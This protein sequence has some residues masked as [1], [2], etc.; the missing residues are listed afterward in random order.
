MTKHIN[1]NDFLSS[2]FENAH[3]VKM[4]DNRVTIDEEG[5]YKKNYK[6][7]WKDSTGT[8][9]DDTVA[10]ILHCGRSNL[11]VIDLD[12]HKEGQDGVK[13]FEELAE[14]HGETIPDTFSVS[15]SSGGVHYY[16]SDEGKPVGPSAGKIADGVDV[17]GD[18]SIIVAPYTKLV[19]PDGTV[20]EYLPLNDSPVLP[21][22]QWLREEAYNASKEG[23]GARKKSQ[24][25]NVPSSPL[26]FDDDE[27][28]NYAKAALDGNVLEMFKT[29]EGARADT[30]Y[31]GAKGCAKAGVPFEVAKDQL[32]AAARTTLLPEDEIESNFNNGFRDGLAEYVPRERSVRP[33]DGSKP[34]KATKPAVDVEKLVEGLSTDAAE[35]I[36]EDAAAD[37]ADLT[38]DDQLTQRFIDNVLKDEAIFL[39]SARK[40]YHYNETEGIW[41][42]ASENWVR[43]PADKFLNARKAELKEAGLSP[44][45]A[46]ALTANNKVFNVAARSTIR[47]EEQGALSDHFNKN[48]SSTVF[49]DGVFDFEADEFIEFSPELRSTQKSKTPLRFNDPTVDKTKLNKIL[50]SL[51]EDTVE[52]LQVA[53]GSGLVNY[54][55]AVNPAILFFNGKGSDGKSTLFMLA[56]K[57][58]GSYTNR[59]LAEV[60][61]K[62]ADIRFAMKGFADT[63]LALF[64]ELPEAHF[65]N[66]VSVKRLVGTPSQSTDVKFGD[67]ITV[68]MGATIFVSTN[69]LPTVTETDEGTWRRLR[70]IQFTKRF[71]ENADPNNPRELEADPELSPLVIKSL[72]DDDEL[73][74][75]FLQWAVEG[76]RKFMKA[77]KKLPPLP[78]SVRNATDNWRNNND[79]MANWANTYF[80]VGTPDDFVLSS[81]VFDCYHY[82]TMTIEKAKSAFNQTNFWKEFE[83]HRWFLTKGLEKKRDRVGKKTQSE[84]TNP[85]KAR[86]DF[87]YL[88]ARPSGDKVMMVRGIKFRDPDVEY[89]PAEART[90]DEPIEASKVDETDDFTLDDFDDADLAELAADLD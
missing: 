70:A 83:E 37:V 36:R 40:W 60:F 64:E 10:Y 43:K 61:A 57:A 82:H 2:K 16:F 42:E 1:I 78:T 33:S 34:T 44:K 67:S 63:R 18:T 65:L 59:P 75:A 20:R 56:E 31:S 29:V 76:A 88:P 19:Y 58:I 86:T 3:A 74:T 15:S 13:R 87:G 72:A 8:I 5:K 69:F 4:P 30:L 22:P 46:N 49:A 66:A 48:F 21:I 73:L 47:L 26:P 71:V 79:R 90:I 17:R 53:F 27:M 14:K 84:W 38:D 50:K 12:F 28:D 23:I 85:V 39:P 77:N 24:R 52:Y 11:I 54:Q 81:D 80:E 9:A 7:S 41:D 68:H 6:F 35:R 55:D 45:V 89:D 25:V 51:P 62:N 32:T